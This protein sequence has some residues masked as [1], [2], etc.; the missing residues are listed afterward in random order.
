M[1]PILFTVNVGN[2]LAPN[3]GSYGW[4]KGNWVKYKIHVV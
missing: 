2:M 3:M 1:I 4:F